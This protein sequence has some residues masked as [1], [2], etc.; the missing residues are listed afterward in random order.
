MWGE[1]RGYFENLR[2]GGGGRREG[3]STLK[4][5]QV[6]PRPVFSSVRKEIFFH[7]IERSLTMKSVAIHELIVD[8]WR[9]IFFCGYFLY[10]FKVLQRF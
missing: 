9:Q 5:K 2:K 6:L 8:K 1:G 7:N 3:V 10:P 4:F